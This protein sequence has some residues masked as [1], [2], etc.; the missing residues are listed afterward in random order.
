MDQQ[1][2]AK[3]LQA[4]LINTLTH[5]HQMSNFAS[6]DITATAVENFISNHNV[7]DYGHEL[8]PLDNAAGLD[9]A[10]RL[11]DGSGLKAAKRLE[12]AEASMGT[13]PDGTNNNES[14]SCVCL[15]PYGEAHTALEITACSHLVGK[16][17]LT[18]WLNSTCPNANTCPYCRH[19]LSSRSN[20]QPSQIDTQDEGTQM[21]TQVE[22]TVAKLVRLCVQLCTQRRE[23]YEGE[24]TL[25]G[26]LEDVLNEV[27]FEFFLND[28]GYC[29]EYMEA[30]ELWVLVRCV[31]WHS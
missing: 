22:Q 25:G 6:S 1:I 11:E 24:C 23:Q 3:S 7:D 2:Y 19:P 15:E 21:W 16:P 13:S 14:H 10:I 17:C 30:T 27:N 5:I 29:L 31:E 26:V 18:R 4:D 12:D 20:A 28:V 8:P 9:G